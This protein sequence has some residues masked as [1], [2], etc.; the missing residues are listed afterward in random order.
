MKKIKL[1]TLSFISLFLFSNNV[2]AGVCKD[3]TVDSYSETCK[4]KNISI[5]ATSK[6]YGTYFLRPGYTAKI[7]GDKYASFCLDPGLAIPP[8]SVNLTYIREI[9]N[10]IN[11]EVGF[12]DDGLYKMFQAFYNDLVYE[13]DNGILDENV[14][15]PLR[16][17][18][19]YAV[20]VWT[21]KNEFDMLEPEDAEYKID[22]ANFKTCANYIDS[23]VKKGTSKTKEECFGTANKY[24]KDGVTYY[25][26]HEYMI[27]KYYN[28]I[29]K[30]Y[31][32]K[33]PLTITT[34]TEEVDK[35]G[36]KYYVYK[37]K[38]SFNDGKYSFFDGTYSKGV[39]TSNINL[40]DSK[41]YLNDLL[42]NGISCSTGGCSNYSGPGTIENVDEKEFIVELTE[43]QY[44]NFKN[45]SADGTVNVSMKYSYQHPLNIENLY[46]ARYDLINSYQ[47]MLVIQNYV[48]EDTYTIGKEP[49]IGLCRH[50]AEGYFNNLGIKVNTL[51]EFLSTCDCS[52]VKKDLLSSSEQTQYNNI[53]GCKTNYAESY[54]GNINSCSSK[55]Y[56]NVLDNKTDNNYENY[57]LGYIR[58]TKVN[59][60]CT[61]KCV[62]DINIYDLKGKYTTKAGR[63][64][65]FDKYPN[66]AAKKRCTIDIDY[67]KWN[68]EY[69]EN[70]KALVEKY[71]VWQE[72]KN[73]SGTGGACC[74]G[75]T[76]DQGVYQ[77]TEYY[78]HYIS[79]YKKAVINGDSNLK[80]EPTT[81]T[82]TTCGTFNWQKTK[83]YNDF[84][85]QSSKETAITNLQKDLKQCNNR[86]YG[87]T[88]NNFYNFSQNLNYNYEQLYS[89]GKT[90]KNSDRKN[91]YG[92]ND[93]EFEYTQGPPIE[94]NNKSIGI[95][96][97]YS[98]LTTSGI[99]NDSIKT[100]IN[101]SDPKEDIQR[102]VDYKVT[103][104]R[105][106]YAKYA[107]AMTG[108]IIGAKTGNLKNYSYLGYG[109]DTD[110][111]AVAQKGNK[112]YY[113]F[114]KLGDSNNK[115]FNHF[116]TG[117]TII[118]MCDYEITNNIM[119]TCENGT[120]DSKLNIIYRS[121][122]PSKIDP[123]GRLKIGE[124]FAN[125]KST[126]AKVVK[127]KIEDD[128]KTH[129]TYSPKNL[130]YSFTL[131]SGTI[132]AIRE[133]NQNY[134]Y[135][136]WNNSLYECESGNKCKSKFISNANGENGK[137]GTIG[138]KFG[139]NMNG[140]DTWKNIKSVGENKYTIDG[141]EVKLNS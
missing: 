61:E 133:D 78:T 30:N 49:S 115:L 22:A 27:K 98:N 94:T 46:T 117:S 65:E 136:D 134:K 11:D 99:K 68:Q 48:H 74:K 116:K 118:R 105:P 125:W 13:R 75:Y 81:T 38:V 70:L 135:D 106:Y 8:S 17:Y 53:E 88:A 67:T 47:R 104:N 109:Y 10:S 73:V 26:K 63:Y 15:G 69:S 60:Y 96:K 110:A 89:N 54:Y 111:S 112:S 76:D 71:N 121:V 119:K 21:Y 7:S 62:E 95:V 32:W 33:N 44:N 137:K 101:N 28:A 43:E 56:E 5:E 129:D 140:R 124:G 102:Q 3:Y 2:Y 18:F 122:D 77:C 14:V 86:L 93:S 113:S 42:I 23:D 87:T 29:S 80:Y 19:Q 1:L 139:T 83:K 6:N 40:F 126:E 108:T 16:A 141:I 127:Q 100:Y 31:I 114:T 45:N 9:D 92:I 50:T 41:F 72:A 51:S 103:Y 82:L 130:E 12:Y 66:L 35:S 36:V 58:D 128:A 85:A 64:F 131:D 84:L 4:S 91:E 132:A 90:I 138:I 20:R 37:F 52:L 120:C 34:N 55:D 97:K 107:E 24:T 25:N 59:E 39:S 123:N 79:N 57:T